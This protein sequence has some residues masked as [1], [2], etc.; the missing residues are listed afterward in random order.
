M[1]SVP[2]SYM[3][4]RDGCAAERVHGKRLSLKNGIQKGKQYF[5][6]VI[7]PDKDTIS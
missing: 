1:P 2:G 6:N 5:K 3:M 4:M 7:I